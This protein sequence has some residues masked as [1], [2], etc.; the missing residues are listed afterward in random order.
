METSV[1]IAVTTPHA[2]LGVGSSHLDLQQH[3]PQYAR[4]DPVPFHG[5][6]HW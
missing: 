4:G 5:Q 2:F 3:K 6:F 1:L